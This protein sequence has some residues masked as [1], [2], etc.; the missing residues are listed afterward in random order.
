VVAAEVAGGAGA[1]LATG[2]GPH[3]QDGIDW[4][5]ALE[6]ARLDQQQRE[7]FTRVSGPY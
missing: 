2:P 3:S 6:A 5:G 7:A 1:D 4:C